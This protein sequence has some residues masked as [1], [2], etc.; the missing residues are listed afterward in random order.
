MHG[1]SGLISLPITF[2]LKDIRGAPPESFTV[3][4][5][6]VIGG[7]KSMQKMASFWGCVIV[8]VSYLFYS[9]ERILISFSNC[10]GFFYLVSWYYWIYYIGKSGYRGGYNI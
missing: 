6:E 8:E 2:M 3:K 1:G 9:L 7:F 4:L 10:R 5:S